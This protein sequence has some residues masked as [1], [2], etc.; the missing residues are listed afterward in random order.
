MKISHL[1][2]MLTTPIKNICVFGILRD[3]VDTT[4]ENLGTR[5]DLLRN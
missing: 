2:P 4:G 3:S 1:A 5:H